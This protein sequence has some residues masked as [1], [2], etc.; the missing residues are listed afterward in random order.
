MV[1]IPLGVMDA[2]VMFQDGTDLEGT[3]IPTT[4][5]R[6]L[7]LGTCTDRPRTHRTTNDSIKKRVL[8]RCNNV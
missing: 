2:I 3:Y 1:H 4:S 7:A 5:S 8:R 6:F